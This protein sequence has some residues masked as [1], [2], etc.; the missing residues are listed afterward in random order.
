[1]RDDN[2]MNRKMNPLRMAKDSI[3]IDN[4]NISLEDQNDF[5][6]SHIDKILKN[7]YRNR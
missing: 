2:D 5:I 3:K 4:S 6:F 7:E 1:M